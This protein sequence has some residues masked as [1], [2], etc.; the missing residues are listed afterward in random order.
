MTYFISL[1]PGNEDMLTQEAIDIIK[2]SDTIIVPGTRTRA[3]IESLRPTGKI[4]DMFVPMAN[5][6]TLA[7]DIYDNIYHFISKNSNQEIAVAVEGD[8]SIYASIHYVIDRLTSNG[9]KV[10]QIAGIPSFIAAAAMA[11]ISLV[12]QQDSL[13]ILPGTL[14]SEKQLADTTIVMKLSKCA[15]FVKRLI[16]EH[17]DDNMYSFHYF[18]NV[19]TPQAIYTCNTKQILTMAFPYFSLM[20]IKRNYNE[21]IMLNKND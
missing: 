15:D 19:S 20:I 13:T 10:K 4:M 14:E 16:E 8:C 2:K 11:G 9:Y 21:D 5:D 12:S 7:N 17:L 3:I 6:R 18:E 1:G